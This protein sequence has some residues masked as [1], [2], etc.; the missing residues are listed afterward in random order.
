MK[1]A[2]QTTPQGLAVEAQYR[3]HQSEWFSSSCHPPPTA[4]RGLAGTHA[5]LLAVVSSGFLQ[6][7][8]LGSYSTWGILQLRKGGGAGNDTKIP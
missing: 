7:N 1:A 4:W 8:T 2:L 3:Q 6:K 5:V